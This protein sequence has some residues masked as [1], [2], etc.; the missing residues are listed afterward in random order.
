MNMICI[1]LSGRIFFAGDGDFCMTSTCS[2]AH[3][4]IICYP[5]PEIDSGGFWQLADYRIQNHSNYKYHYN[6]LIL[7]GG[8]DSSAP[9]PPPR[10]I[11]H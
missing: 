3:L 11:I 8:G 4:K 6:F 5:R 7:G 2:S 9:R 1:Q 10:S